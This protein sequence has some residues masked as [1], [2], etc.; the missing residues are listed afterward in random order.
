M[1]RRLINDGFTQFIAKASVEAVDEL[2]YDAC[3]LWVLSHSDDD[4]EAEANDAYFNKY[5][6]KEGKHVS[7]MIVLEFSE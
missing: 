5:Q 4:D 3:Y 7:N 2:D 6:E 1:I